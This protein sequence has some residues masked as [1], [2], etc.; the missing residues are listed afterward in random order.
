M[1]SL[2]CLTVL[3]LVAGSVQADTATSRLLRVHEQ[4]LREFEA[5]PTTVAASDAIRSAR[6]V[7]DALR[8]QLLDELRD[9]AEYR[10][11]FTRENQLRTE[12]RQLQHKFRHGIVPRDLA[13]NLSLEILQLQTKRHKL[14]KAKLEG[15]RDYVIARDRLTAAG[16]IYSDKLRW[17]PERIRS[18]PRFQQAL[19]ASGRSVR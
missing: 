1:R 9:T 11:L 12:V 13:N 17:I 4:I 2:L 15:D 3:L 5:D 16:I 6:A 14:I 8:T 7:H 10:K 18:D 19:R